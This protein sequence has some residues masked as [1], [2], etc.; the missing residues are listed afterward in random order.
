M[1]M[2][3]ALVKW[4]ISV[5]EEINGVK[6]CSICFAVF[7]MDNYDLAQNQCNACSKR[8][9]NTCIVSSLDNLPPPSPPP[10]PYPPPPPPP[11]PPPAPPPPT[12]PPPPPT[13]PPPHHPPAPP[14]PALPPPPLPPPPPTLPPPHHPHPLTPS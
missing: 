9:H 13:L 8:F 5:D 12:L 7:H 1:E 6:N 11:P 4:R 10:T 2:S 3:Y 14:P